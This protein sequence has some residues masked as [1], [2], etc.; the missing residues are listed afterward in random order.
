MKRL[1][2][3]HLKGHTA[4]GVNSAVPVALLASATPKT[5]HVKPAMYSLPCKASHVKLPM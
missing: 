2:R 3:A 1:V 5:T 4:K